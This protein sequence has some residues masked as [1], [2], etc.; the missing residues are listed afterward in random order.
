MTETEMGQERQQRVAM[1][2]QSGGPATPESLHARLDALD[3]GQDG[4]ARSVGT[5]RSGVRWRWGV[6]ATAAAAALAAAVV[7]ISFGGSSGGISATQVASVWTRPA[8]SGV[9]ADASNP[10]V[11]DV[12]FHGTAYPN[13]HDTEGWHP[14]GTRT[15]QINGQAAFTVVYAVGAR[16][17]AYT[18]VAGTHV[19]IPRG[20]SHYS[21]GGL[22]F[23]EFRSGNHWIIVFAN[24]GNTCVLTAAAPRE[25][26]WLVKLAVWSRAP[27]GA[28]A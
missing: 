21:V 14:T 6:P 23:A 3:A 22:R 11:L 15:D 8:T 4:R 19:A 12:S 16:R 24:H 10:A 20:A 25:Q 2:L 7:L 13:Y 9:A 28:H 17:A 1:L 18:V 5:A 27:S 26:H